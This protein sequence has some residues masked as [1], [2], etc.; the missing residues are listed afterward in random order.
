MK[1]MIRFIYKKIF[2][3]LL[4]LPSCL[5]AQDATDSTI[6][7]G[8][9]YIDYE[10]DINS[11]PKI[12][13]DTIKIKEVLSKYAIYPRFAKSKFLGGTIDI[14]T[15][16][17]QAG[18]ISEISISNPYHAMFDTVAIR[19]VLA[20]KGMWE[21]AIVKGKPKGRVITIP[22]TFRISG[23]SLSH[24]I[25]YSVNIFASHLKLSSDSANT[26]PAIVRATDSTIL[27]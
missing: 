9:E 16:I 5:L 15:T 10:G 11:L 23:D 24:A 20:T 6:M 4:F 2:I 3:I 25:E 7:Y 14:I 21:P 18:A 26:F 19:L 17:D 12:K 22:V 27:I 13:V 8:Y 1:R